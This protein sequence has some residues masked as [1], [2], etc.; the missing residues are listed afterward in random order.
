MI[1]RSPLR[2]LC[3]RPD[4]ALPERAVF[5]LDAALVWFWFIL[6]EAAGSVTGACPLQGGEGSLPLVSQPA[7]REQLLL[8]HNPSRPGAGTAGAELGGAAWPPQ[9]CLLTRGC[10]CPGGMGACLMSLLS[11]KGK[12]SKLRC[13]LWT[14]R[15]QGRMRPKGIPATLISLHDTYD[16]S[17][18]PPPA[19]TKI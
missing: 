18:P 10:Q 8:A 1:H 15:I 3:C 6:C 17:T 5:H 7:G 16:T 14:S 9:G 11:Y 13:W 2:W 19:Q 4:V 12:T